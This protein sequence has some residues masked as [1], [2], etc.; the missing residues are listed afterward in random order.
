MIKLRLSG[1]VGWDITADSVSDFLDEHD[2][3]DITLF[4]NSPGGYV[5]EGLEIYNLL[6]ASGRNITTVLTGMAASMGSILFLAGDKRIAMSGTL[7]MIHKPSGIAW[8]DASE[9]RKEAEIL[10]KMQGSL[11]E[12]YEERA[13]IENLE[14]L[15]NA[16][17]W[18][19]VKE[20]EENGIVNSDEA[21]VFDGVV[22]PNND[23]E[24]DDQTII[25]LGS[26]DN[27]AKKDDLQ[28]EID[29][30]K[31]QKAQLEEQAE[32][33]RLEAELATMK[34]DVDKLK[35]EAEETSELVSEPKEV[36]E[37]E[38]TIEPETEEDDEIETTVDP[39]PGEAKV[40]KEE[41]AVID[42][43]KTVAVKQNNQV[44]AYMQVESKY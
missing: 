32:E 18:F 31:A 20:M 42:T 29:E 11:Q 4:L 28:A 44:P 24:D 27:M 38:E 2:D 6:R 35:A 3:K 30:L 33:A 17:S 25:I 21:V 39:E 14:E 5:V 19:N 15:I 26:E 8:G 7:F 36:V 13:S 10:D 12:I 40:E 22:D 9:M 23:E 34:A 41:S 1:V 43:T 16:E 37:P